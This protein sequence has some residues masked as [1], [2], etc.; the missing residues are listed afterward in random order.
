MK[1]FSHPRVALI[2]FSLFALYSLPLKNKD[3]SIKE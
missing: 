1:L 2:I 3:N